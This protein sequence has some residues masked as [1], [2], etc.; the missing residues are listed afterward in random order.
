MRVRLPRLCL[1]KGQVAVSR[2]T[3]VSYKEA[4]LYV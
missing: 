3:V 4:L 1:N 2:L